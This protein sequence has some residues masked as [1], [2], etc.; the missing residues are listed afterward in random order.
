MATIGSTSSGT[1]SSAGIGSGLDVNSI[2]TQLMAIESRPLTALQTKASTIQSTVSEYGKI[3][4]AFSAL[5]DL[6]V[7]LAGSTTWAQS[8][9]TSTDA[10]VAATTNASSPG[11]Y[12]VAVSQ[13]ASVQT[14][15]TGV[16]ADASATIGAGAL[17]IEL[18]TWGAN[19]ASFVPKAGATAVDVSI[20]ATDTLTEVRD[21]IN[22]AGAGVTALIMTDSSGSRLLLRSNT[23][24]A[25]NA[26]RTSGGVNALD[27]DPSSGAAG[28]MTQSQVAAD[29]AATVNGLAVTSSS[30]TFANIVDGLTL[31]VSALT[32]SPAT[33]TVAT[34]KTALKKAITDF[35]AA[36]T[37]IYKLIAT[38]THYDATAKQGGIL[39]GDSA[40]VGLQN[41]LRALAGG[42][43]GAS[44]TFARLS[45]AGLQ[46][47]VDGSMTVDDTKLGNALGNLAE[48]KKAFANTD[49]ADPTQ[50]GFAKRFRTA[51]D[52]L[53]GIDGSLSTRTQGLSD[54]L[55][56]NQTDQEHLNTR[57]AGVERRLRAQY[58]ALD[59]AMAT[60]TSQSSYI[61][62][63]VA[64]WNN[65]KSTGG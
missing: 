6:A 38:D 31:N 23:T 30:N 18:G 45:D 47:Q 59:K 14:L 5:N 52:A 7:K 63:Q 21:K 56:R 29:A 28:T 15:A 1:L 58:T 19:Q 26:F 49:P 37:A 3:K 13:L 22:A 64:A 27:F 65:S 25:A 39:Q 48:L 2:V 57:L 54:A 9:A 51:T 8:T 43:T 24:G 62:Q 32:T 50:D 36:Y 44:S 33:V 35:A 20:A 53:L 10:S 34:D 12:S 11:T 55:R 46:I 16:F 61:T 60:L 4:S 41:Q 40:A 42:V 17:H